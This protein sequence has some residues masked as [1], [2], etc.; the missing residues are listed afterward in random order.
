MPS[1]DEADLTVDDGG[2]VT[3]S[4]QGPVPTPI[5]YGTINGLATGLATDIGAPGGGDRYTTYL[6]S[7]NFT[8]PAGVS[9]NGPFVV[10]FLVDDGF[11]MYLD[12]EEVD[13]DVN[14]PDQT[15]VNC[16]NDIGGTRVPLGP[17]F[18]PTFL[19]SGLGTTIDGLDDESNFFSRELGDFTLGAGSHMIAVSL[20]QVNN[21]S[22]DTAFQ[23]RLYTPGSGRPWG[24]DFSG[25]WDDPINWAVG[26]PTS[27]QFAVFNSF[28]AQHTI[29]S[30]S[31]QSLD[32][33]QFE[34]PNTH[35]IAGVG[36]IN[37]SA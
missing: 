19:D 33:I 25:D 14:D 1:Y 28:N 29:W 35:N 20:H 16:C 4:W 36:S 2:P 18:P 12:G 6:R 23:M 5:G 34:D 7:E 3:L 37:R 21:T 32:G 30:D 27:Q 24:G 22:S 10:E 15:R 8:R 11:V 13:L 17:N 9:P 31:A 26:I